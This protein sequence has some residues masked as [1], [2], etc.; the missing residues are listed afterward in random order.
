[1][2]HDEGRGVCL[3][4]LVKAVAVLFAMDKKFNARTVILKSG[5]LFSLSGQSHVLKHWWQEQVSVRVAEKAPD[6]SDSLSQSVRRY[7]VGIVIDPLA[8]DR[9]LSFR[10]GTES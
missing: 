3:Q 4:V 8:R 9:L 10:S 6:I 2:S 7:L 5:S 1:M